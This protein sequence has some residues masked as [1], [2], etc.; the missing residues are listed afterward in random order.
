M[1]Y[2]IIHDA[3]N[4]I[5]TFLYVVIKTNAK[6]NQFIGILDNKLKIAINKKPINGLA[7]KAL[8]KILARSLS[9]RQNDIIVDS[10]I[11]NNIKVLKISG[12]I[13]DKLINLIDLNSE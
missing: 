7:N 6:N 4:D 11:N 9:I 1:Y 3:Y 10:G 13:S 5:Y 2:K 8:I 12:D